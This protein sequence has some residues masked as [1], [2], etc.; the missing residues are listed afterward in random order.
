MLSRQVADKLQQKETPFYFYDLGL[1]E[2]TL[3]TLTGEA[4]KYGYTIHYAIKANCDPRVIETIRRYG[5][6]ID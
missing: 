1:L 3:E 4:A 6:G 5:V 2:R